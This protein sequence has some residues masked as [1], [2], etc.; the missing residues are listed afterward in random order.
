[1]KQEIRQIA[2]IW[3][4][5]FDERLKWLDQKV[6]DMTTEDCVAIAAALNDRK[7]MLGIYIKEMEIKA[8]EA[9]NKAGMKTAVVPGID[10]SM[11]SVERTSKSAR[12]EVKRD[13]LVAAVE[14]LVLTNPELRSDPFS[15]EIASLD[16]TR[17]SLLKRCFRF[18]P[19]W[20]DLQKVGIKVDD[21]AHT[22]WSSTVKITKAATL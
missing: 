18:E 2:E 15:G 1:M 16:E 20:T 21:F 5:Q 9:L 3:I 10:G 17:I 13:E 4:S 11:L 19:R 8:C 6:D 22:E 7:V 12:T 14:R